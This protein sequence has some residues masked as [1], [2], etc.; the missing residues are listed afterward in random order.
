MTPDTATPF[1]Y[2]EAVRIPAELVSPLSA[3]AFTRPV[4]FPLSLEP[5][6]VVVAAAAAPDD[7]AVREA[8]GRTY[9]GHDVRLVAASTEDLA[10]LAADFAPS[11]TGSPV[12]VIRTNL[13]FWRNT[14][15]YCY[16]DN[17]SPA[18]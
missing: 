11:V 10:R 15:K 7:P 3:A 1:V 4:W 14:M 9:P 13:A 17:R 8:V 12:G 16:G 6:P 5:G 18:C 2:D